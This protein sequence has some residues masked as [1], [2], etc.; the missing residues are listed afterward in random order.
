VVAVTVPAP[1]R[2][3]VLARARA[4]Q[5]VTLRLDPAQVAAVKRLARR[6][7]VPYARL[8]RTWIADGLAKERGG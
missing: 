7:R 3:R 8:L 6:R 1:L 4:K 2:R 5:A